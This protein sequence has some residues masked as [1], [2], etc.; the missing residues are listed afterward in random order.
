MTDM[1]LKPTERKIFAVGKIVDGLTQIICDG[2]EYQIR[3]ES[4]RVIA[5]HRT[6]DGKW[7]IWKIRP[8]SR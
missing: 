8:T 5:R 1:Q 6:K 4:G 3:N 2:A 7:S